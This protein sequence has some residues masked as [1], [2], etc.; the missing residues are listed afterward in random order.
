MCFLI[1]GCAF[2]IACTPAAGPEFISLLSPWSAELRLALFTVVAVALV[3]P[4]AFQPALARR[5]AIQPGAGQPGA[6]VRRQGL[7][8]RSSSGSC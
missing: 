2:A 7:L 3:A 5:N 6:A 8:R 1:A 4:V